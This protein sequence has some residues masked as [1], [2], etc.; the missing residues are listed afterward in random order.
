MRQTNEESNAHIIRLADFQRV[1]KNHP[2][3]VEISKWLIMR[4]T[5]EESNA[6]IIR[7]ADFQ[8]VS[9]NHPWGVEI[10]K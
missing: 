6:H 2:R 4:Q 10:S 9:K 5:N 7:F 3:G 8:R 1:S